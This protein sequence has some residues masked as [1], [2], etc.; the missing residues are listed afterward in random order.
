MIK[1]LRTKASDAVNHNEND[2]SF[3]SISSK[4]SSSSLVGSDTPFDSPCK[5]PE[6]K[7]VRKEKIATKPVKKSLKKTSEIIDRYGYSTRGAALLINSYLQDT[8]KVSEDN[9][10]EII[11]RD[12]LKYD[13]NTTRD[14]KINT[15]RLD[16]V[17][18]LIFD[19]RKD[20]TKVQ[21]NIEVPRF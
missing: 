4:A 14:D 11:G 6:R 5:E 8:G 17:K 9:M 3:F 10:K 20:K 7:R 1:V 12:K 2:L 16:E 18:G 19:G 15:K 13:L 21:V